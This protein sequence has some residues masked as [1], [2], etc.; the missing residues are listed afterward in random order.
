M[1][2]TFPKSEAVI[3]ESA[4]FYKSIN[5]AD[6][7]H[8]ILDKA[9]AS[10]IKSARI[11]RLLGSIYTANGNNENARK[12]FYNALKINPNDSWAYIGLAKTTKADK[13]ITLIPAINT[14]LNKKTCSNNEKSGLTF[15]KAW[16]IKKSDPEG[17]FELLTTANNFA[18]QDHQEYI[19]QLEP[20][21]REIRENINEDALNSIDTSKQNHTYSPIF[22][23]SLP[24]S[25]TT[26]LEQIIGAHSQTS[27][28]GESGA[29]SYAIMQAAA[30]LKTSTNFEQWPSQKNFSNFLPI[31]DKHF[32]SYL[33]VRE[34]KDRRPVDKSLLSYKQLGLMFATYPNAKI[35]HIQRHPLDNILSC[36]HQF[37]ENH[38]NHLFN[39]EA[40]ALNSKMFNEQMSYWKTV[41]PK[42]I[43]T[44]SYEDLVLQQEEKTRE[45]LNYCELPYEEQCL[46]FYEHIGTI[47]TAS[48]EQVRQPMYKSS[49]GQWKQFE[50][51]LQP[52]IRILGMDQS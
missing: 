47:N 12:N 48:N 2:K 8:S 10:N 36:Y 11:Y 40:L 27:P 38:H 46:K 15:T 31:L 23:I 19:D 39:L 1:L 37:F 16:A 41:F 4:I 32:Q 52:A 17:Y 35:I 26:L 44:V 29:F 33:P 5:D 43:L 9:I 13:F 24:R 51:Q 28:I 22:I 25:G 6:S 18:A 42:K 30:Q 50:Q 14:I 3:A 49:I 7:A 34:S 45:I 20:H 21:L